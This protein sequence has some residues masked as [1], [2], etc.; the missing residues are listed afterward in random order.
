MTHTTVHLTSD[1]RAAHRYVGSFS[2]VEL[3]QSSRT[4]E[5]TFV[6]NETKIFVDQASATVAREL[7]ACLLAAADTHDP[8]SE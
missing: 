6:S 8:Q 4:E 1:V 5:G 7:A 2:S 3:V